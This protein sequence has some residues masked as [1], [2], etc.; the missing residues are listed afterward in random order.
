M[1]LKLHVIVK[2]SDDHLVGLCLDLNVVACGSSISELKQ[3]MKDAID[4]YLEHVQANKLPVRRPVPPEILEDF[5][6]EG[7]AIAPAGIT[8]PIAPEP[9]FFIPEPL[10][11]AVG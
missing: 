3:N 1:E 2:Q 6:S 10:A 7:E 4:I 8:W 9:E 5:V 11:G